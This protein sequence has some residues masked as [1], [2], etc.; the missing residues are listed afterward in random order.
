MMRRLDI[1][2]DWLPVDD[3]VRHVSPNHLI[4]GAWRPA[5]RRLDPDLRRRYCGL[6]SVAS[7][8]PGRELG[9]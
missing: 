1:D 6:A 2:I 7:S 9:A 8:A 4:Q 3:T 5:V